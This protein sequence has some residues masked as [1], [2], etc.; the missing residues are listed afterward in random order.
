MFSSQDLA[1]IAMLMMIVGAVGGLIGVAAILK[2]D[3][4]D[5]GDLSKPLVIVGVGL[6]F[7]GVFLDY[8]WGTF[9]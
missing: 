8:R 7:L 4:L 2:S 5:R 3:G 1:T 9:W 6:F